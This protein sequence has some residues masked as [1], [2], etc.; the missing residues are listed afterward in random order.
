MALKLFLRVSVRLKGTHDD[1]SDK[2][3]IHLKAKAV[4]HRWSKAA[5]NKIK[6]YLQHKI[7]IPTFAFFQHSLGI[8]GRLQFCLSNEKLYVPL[9]PPSVGTSSRAGGYVR[10]IEATYTPLRSKTL[11]QEI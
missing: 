9:Q 10:G 6:T 2:Q 3:K 8:S 5:N 1:A 7:S 4:K 11:P